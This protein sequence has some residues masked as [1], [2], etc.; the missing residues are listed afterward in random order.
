MAILKPWLSAL[1]VWVVFCIGNKPFNQI[2]FDKLCANILL[3][4]FADTGLQP[5]TK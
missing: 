1:K 4:M 5:K 2:H 3:L